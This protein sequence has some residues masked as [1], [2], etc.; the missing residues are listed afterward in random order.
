M[1]HP[2]SLIQAR[3]F[4]ILTSDATLMALITGVFDGMPENQEYPY[5]NIGEYFLGDFGSHTTS[6]VDG[7]ITL[8]AWSQTVG[9]KSVQMILNR[10]YSLLHAIDLAITGFPTITFRCSLNQVL[11]DPDGRT[12]HG[13]QK[14]RLITGGN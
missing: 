1:T 9:N 2:Q 13:V 14:Y 7:T 10:M 3:I 8:H 5:V 6:G 11:D 12:K 4:A